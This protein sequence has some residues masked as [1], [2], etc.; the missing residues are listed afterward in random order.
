MIE[1]DDS[2]VCLRAVVHTCRH[3]FRIDR[4]HVEEAAPHVTCFVTD[5][6]VFT[7]PAILGEL[8]RLGYEL[9]IRQERIPISI[10][11]WIA[12]SYTPEVMECP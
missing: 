7:D 2:V 4:F 8:V 1:R 12:G 9:H 3:D 10:G 5:G 11:E 6:E